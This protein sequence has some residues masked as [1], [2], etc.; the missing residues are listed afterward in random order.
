[1]EFR[2]LIM[3]ETQLPAYIGGDTPFLNWP[4]QQF[5]AHI[6]HFSTY[7]HDIG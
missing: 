1:M 4:T 7:L 2:Q 6:C 5:G 3:L